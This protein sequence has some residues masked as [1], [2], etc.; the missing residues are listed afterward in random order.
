MVFESRSRAITLP[1][2]RAVERWLAART[3]DLPARLRAWFHG[4]DSSSGLVHDF[5]RVCC[6]L[7]GVRIADSQT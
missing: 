1:T 7:R 4:G 2:V 6:D 3:A 5:C